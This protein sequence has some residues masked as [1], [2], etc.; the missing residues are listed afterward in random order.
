[1]SEEE[2]EESISERAIRAY[3]ATNWEGHGVNLERVQRIQFGV[4]DEPMLF[5]ESTIANMLE[6][7]ARD[8]FP[9]DAFVLFAVVE[10]LRGNDEHHR[11]VLRQKKPGKWVSPT[12]FATR[13]ERHRMWLYALGNWEREGIKTE[14]AVARI[15]ELEGVSRASVFAGIRDAEEDI[16]RAWSLFHPEGFQGPR[17]IHLMNPRPT[18][19]AEG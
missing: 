5:D 8:A 14:A 19:K 4:E 9:D 6:K 13:K 7:I 10:A 1:M 16:E 15:A 17:P 3:E 18:I 2:P 11:L 12:E